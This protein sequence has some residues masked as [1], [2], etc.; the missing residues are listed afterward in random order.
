MKKKILIIVS[1]I[2]VST[3]SVYFTLAYLTDKKTVVNT[4]TVGEVNISLKETK[5]DSLGI[6]LQDE[7][8]TTNNKYHLL[9]G[10]TYTKDPTLTVEAGS[11]EAYIRILVTLNMYK[12]LKE[13]FN[14]E[15]SP[16]NYIEGY[17]K[18]KWIYINN[19][20]NTKENTITYEF[21]YYKTVSGYN[22]SEKESVTLEPLFTKIKVPG[23]IETK[24]LEKISDLEIKVVGHAIQSSGFDSVDVAW[25][26][27]NEQN[28]I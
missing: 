9:P 26:A 24:D 2:L 22:N 15:F 18:D 19:K 14:N 23:E 16:I 1:F 20:V 28:G 8:K 11:E 13:I 7:E 25:Q 10:K 27:F 5:V 12:E 21:R 17:N 6:P 3:L 4:F